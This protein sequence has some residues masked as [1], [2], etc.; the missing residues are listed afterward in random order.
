MTAFLAAPITSLNPMIGAGFVTSAMELWLRKPKMQDF[1][2][3]RHDTAYFK[4]WWKN[5]ISRTLL[6]FIFSSLGSAI[7]TYIA[8]LIIYHRIS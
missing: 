7:G 2:N 6:V 1:D 5:R 4:G 8:G 3:L